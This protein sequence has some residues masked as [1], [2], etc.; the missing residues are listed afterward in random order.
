MLPSKFLALLI[1]A[2]SLTLARKITK[3]DV[4][5]RQLEAA[6]RFVPRATGPGVPKPKNI[7]FSNPRASG[8]LWEL[9]DSV[10]LD[11]LKNRILGQWICHP[12]GRL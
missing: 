12:R 1:A 2:A 6:A 8:T 7:T 11:P 4:R 9:L 3:A 5:K 10:L